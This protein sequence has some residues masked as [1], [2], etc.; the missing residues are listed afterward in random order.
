[1]VSAV[2]QGRWGPVASA[3]GD[4]PEEVRLVNGS[5][6]VVVHGLEEAAALDELAVEVIHVVVAH[7]VRG[8]AARV[9]DLARV[10]AEADAPVLHEARRAHA[11]R[12]VE[13]G[14]L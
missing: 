10:A 3:T 5:V 2:A 12:P 4:A 14:A 11:H 13:R 6:A 8:P 9:L 7:V 1:M